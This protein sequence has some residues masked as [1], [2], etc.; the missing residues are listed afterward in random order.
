MIELKN[1]TKIYKSKRKGKHKALDNI[2]LL[3]GNEGLIFVLGKSGSGKSTLLNLI[4]GLDSITSGNIIVDGNDIS[5]FNERRFADYRNNHIGFIFQ[6][7][8]LLEELTVYENILLAL[9]LT[10]RVDNGEI[11]ESLKK[12]GLEGYENRFPSELSGGERQRVA[13]ARAIVKN[14]RIILAD[15]PTGNLDNITATAIIDLLKFLSKDCLI[16]IVSHNT[17]DTYKY[18]D[19]IIRLNKGTVLSD[20]TRNS[21]FI[22]DLKFE[23]E[24][25]YYPYLRTLDSQDIENINK[26]IKENKIKKM[27]LVENKFL[28]TEKNNKNENK[29]IEILREKPTFKS[30]LNICL[31]FLK[32]KVLRIFT[33][34]FIV[35]VIM[36]ILS[37][38]QT[39]INFDSGE[40]IKKEMI[41]Q[42][43]TSLFVKK[44]NKETN[45]FHEYE[46]YYEV[47]EQKTIDNFKTKYQDTKV[48][49]LVNSSVPITLNSGAYNIF[50]SY[51]NKQM[52]DET[53]GTLIV[54]EEFFI[55]KVG[56][57]EFV[58]KLDDFDD[59]GV[60]ITDFT[61]DMILGYGRRYK[62]KEY[63]DILGVYSLDTETTK[64][65]YINGIIKTNYKAKYQELFSKLLKA[66]QEELKEIYEGQEYF[67]FIN[68]LYDYLG[69]SFSFNPNFV[70]A[71]KNDPINGIVWTHNLVFNNSTRAIFN[72]GRH[73]LLGKNMNLK[74]ELLDN[75]VTMNY[76]KYN[77]MFKTN[78][79]TATFKDFVPQEVSIKQYQLYDYEFK[80]PL[81]EIKVKIKE[82]HTNGAMFIA[83]DKVFK[84]FADHSFFYQGIY[85]EGLNSIGK[86]IEECNKN[87]YSFQSYTVEGIST[88]IR[89][90]EVFVPIFELV[91]G[92]LC[93]GII[94]ILV[95]FLFKMIKDKYHDIGILKALGSKNSTIGMIF[96][97]QLLLLAILTVILSILGYYFFIDQAND[98]LISSLKQLAEHRVVLD[99]EILSYKP[100]IALSNS[101]LI[102]VLSIISFVVPMI[103][104]CRIKPVQ[105]I[106]TKE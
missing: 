73:V 25:V 5:T 75:E 21:S 93:V 9:K 68:D 102:V 35:A 34:S 36:V 50:H 44:Q 100:I 91:G 92:F 49:P 19:R 47:I 11:R 105:I 10:R 29:K 77:E 62:N 41:K 80:K 37:L 33:S 84:E 90:V 12:V 22:D 97:L 8:H 59:R 1:V 104:I 99:L 76:T 15:E 106:K 39:I 14:P 83:S 95:N 57:L 82:L 30:V 61:A 32:N 58:E 72:N 94:F 52:L 42:N 88:M 98:V 17:S 4:G 69:Y 16:I 96:G 13:I 74:E 3:F 56:N 85:F 38:A 28:D 26:G 55:N 6:D 71:S 89:A 79:T 101:G 7:Y 81:K 78:Y 48:Y 40:V 63:K 54:D 43:Q 20:Q 70:E 53:F 87:K 18:A 24:E 66:N 65:A 67:S 46:S 64:N 2:N 45:I 27:V 60:L 86:I 51:L 31:T 103:K 23:N